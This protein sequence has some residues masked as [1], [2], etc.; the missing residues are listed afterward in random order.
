MANTIAAGYE[1][2]SG[3]V[4]MDLGAQEEFTLAPSHTH[5]SHLVLC[6]SG[7]GRGARSEPAGPGSR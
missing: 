2:K 3:G 4:R 7:G 6:L 5:L 1:L